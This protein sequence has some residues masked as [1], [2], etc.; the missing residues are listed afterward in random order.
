MVSTEED[1]FLIILHV[2][3]I[4]Y[5]KK[6]S[7][8]ELRETVYRKFG[9]VPVH[10]VVRSGYVLEEAIIDEAARQQVDRIV[11]GSKSRTL[12]GKIALL[13]GLWT[14]LKTVLEQE[15]DIEIETI[16]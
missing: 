5:S 12:R 2:P 1:R 13:L 11:I 9:K 3:L 7:R 8:N 15:L 4:Q 10:F 6:A 16:G 14:D